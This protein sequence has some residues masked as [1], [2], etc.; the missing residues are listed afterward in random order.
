MQIDKLYRPI[1]RYFRSPRMK[2][3]IR[4]FKVSTETTVLDIGGTPF[5]WTLNSIRPV[6]TIVNLDAAVSP[7]VV[8][9]ARHL[10]FKDGSFDIVY[11]NSV[12][13]HVGGWESQNAFAAECRRVG[14]RYYVQTPNKWFP[15]EPHWIAPFIHWLPL[16]ARYLF[17]RNF[18]LRGIL[19]RPSREW[20]RDFL[21]Q[22]RLLT[23]PEM[24]EL[25]PDG[26]VWRERFGGLTKSIIVVKR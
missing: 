20:C 14:K 17:A 16:R 8:C 1:Q 4:E 22:T 12:V 15:I 23:V 2:R 19:A 3:F 21:D 13:E 6:L 5:N 25:F 11:S 10:P 18:T 9:D 26:Q 7:T 24:R